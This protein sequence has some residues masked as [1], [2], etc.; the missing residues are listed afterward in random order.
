MIEPKWERHGSLSIRIFYAKD[1]TGIHDN[2]P[3]QQESLTMDF[4]RMD[5]DL[6]GLPQ[7]LWLAPVTADGE[8]KKCK[9][10]S[11]EHGSAQLEG[12]SNESLEILRNALT[13][14]GKEATRILNGRGATLHGLPE[15]QE[16]RTPRGLGEG[17]PG[18]KR[19]PGPPGEPL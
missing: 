16:G 11:V 5:F 19:L 17:A 13:N 15:P 8:T 12:M 10:K 6:F 4:F 1:A 2:F 18:R 3:L 14:L 7:R 9:V